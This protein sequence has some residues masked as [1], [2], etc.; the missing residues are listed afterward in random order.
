MVRMNLSSQELDHILETKL[1]N[2]VFRLKESIERTLQGPV[3]PNF[4]YCFGFRTVRKVEELKYL[5]IL[6]WYLEE[7][8][9]LL[10]SD[11]HERIGRYSLKDQLELTL[12]CKSKEE[13]LTLLTH[14]WS[15]RDFFGNHLKGILLRAKCLRFLTSTPHRPVRAVRRR[16]YRDHGSCSL[17][18][19][20]ARRKQ[21]EDYSFTQMQLDLEREQEH[22]A[23]TETL[24]GSF[25][26]LGVRL[27]CLE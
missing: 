1:S 12:L 2:E 24:I 9:V 8:G 20:R 16:G 18:D 4:E 11:I 27:A 21:S 26:L 19:S 6:S 14:R 13:C 7:Y 15:E 3:T 23:K 5:C 25:G 10:R 22:L 17:N